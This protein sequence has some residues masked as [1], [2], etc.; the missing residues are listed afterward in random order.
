MAPLPQIFA[1]LSGLDS[2]RHRRSSN[3][4]ALLRSLKKNKSNK[5]TNNPSRKQPV[6]P[7][8]RCWSR[9]PRLLQNS[10]Q[11]LVRPSVSFRT[12]RRH[13]APDQRQSRELGELRKQAKS[14][15]ASDIRTT[16]Y[17]MFSN[18][19]LARHSLKYCLRWTLLTPCFI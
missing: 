16:N 10:F 8:G 11:A 3:I 7:W 4:L 1:V 9:R 12:R 15:G 6:P 2:V 17:C 13:R 5:Q 18:T 19:V 14:A